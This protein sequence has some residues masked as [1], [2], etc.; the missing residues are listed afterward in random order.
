MIIPTSLAG[1]VS[2]NLHLDDLLVEAHTA[3]VLCLRQSQHG[4]AMILWHQ[5][6]PGMLEQRPKWIQ[7][8]VLLGDP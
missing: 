8:A 1:L 6:A 2:I 4:V 3:T 7:V 5:D